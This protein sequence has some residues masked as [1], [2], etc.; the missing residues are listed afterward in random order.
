MFFVIMPAY[1]IEMVGITRQQSAELMFSI[2]LLIMVVGK[3]NL[4]AKV[5]IIISLSALAVIFHYSLFLIILSYFAIAVLVLIGFRNRT[6][7][8][9]WLMATVGILLAVGIGYFGTISSGIPLKSMSWLGQSQM[10]RLSPETVEEPTSEPLQPTS[11]PAEIN[12][13]YIA[14]ANHPTTFAD[15]EVMMQTALG[16][17]MATA[18]PLG[19]GFRI[20]QGITQTLIVIGAVVIIRKRKQLS[21]EYFAFCIGSIV[22]MTLCFAMP[23]FSSMLNA[24]RFYRI[25]LM[26]LAPAVVIGGLQVVKRYEIF[27]L[28]ILVPYFLLSSGFAFE[29]TKSTTIER[30]DLPFSTALSYQRVDLGGVFTDNDITVRDYA[31]QNKLLPIYGDLYGELILEESYGLDGWG[32]G[33]VYLPYAHNLFPIP[34]EDIIAD[35]YIF[36][37]ER[38]ME[39]EIVTFWH[40]PGLRQS[41]S[42]ADYGLV[43]ELA[44]REIIYQKG[45]AVLYGQRQ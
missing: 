13:A 31:W 39:E 15:H 45:N 23:G 8:L 7:P 32:K 26:L 3:F 17:D 37:R 21:P 40:G 20:F 30:I 41:H 29:A 27:A 4:K 11:L 12:T 22:I 34:K 5:P 19:K 1:S 35:S 33:L 10:Y 6:I 43:E 28:G 18:T 14:Q 36:L 16:M 44:C 25:A 2:M 42:F 9:K 24:S 38:N